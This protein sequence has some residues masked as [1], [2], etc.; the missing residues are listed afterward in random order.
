MESWVSVYTR[1]ENHPVPNF[2]EG[3][4]VLAM[5]EHG[6]LKE[7]KWALCLLVSAVQAIGRF[8][9]SFSCSPWFETPS[10]AQTNA[11]IPNPIN[12]KFDVCRKT[13]T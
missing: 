3:E 6:S 10:Q 2:S 4:N 12:D 5:L 9:Q 7:L 13:V 11:Y 8:S 1:N